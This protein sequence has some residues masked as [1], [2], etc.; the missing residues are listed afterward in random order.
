MLALEAAATRTSDAWVI[1]T[2][3]CDDAESMMLLAG[4]LLVT[5]A[6]ELA[7]AST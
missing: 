6:K 1:A 4:D 2:W 7:E 5:P 3:Y